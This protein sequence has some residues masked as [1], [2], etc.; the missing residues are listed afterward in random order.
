[1]CWEKERS[2]SYCALWKTDMKLVIFSTWWS[3]IQAKS[4]MWKIVK[5]NPQFNF[6][7]QNPSIELNF[8]KRDGNITMIWH[9][10]FH[11]I[12]KLILY[13]VATF[14]K[15]LY[16]SEFASMLSNYWVF[17]AQYQPEINCLLSSGLVYL[18]WVSN[19]KVEN[20][21]TK[22]FHFLLSQKVLE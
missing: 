16:R 1:M 22:D 10:L 15:K 4:L 11:R 14:W 8:L 17:F 3:K 19:M 21:M 20:D 6:S 13:Y 2:A 12:W 9:L 7:S 5:K 18:S